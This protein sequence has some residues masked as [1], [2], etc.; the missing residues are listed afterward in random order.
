MGLSSMYDETEYKQYTGDWQRVFAW[1]PVRTISGER[2]WLQR[3]YRGTYNSISGQG[4]EYAT[5]VDLIKLHERKKNSEQFW[6]S[7]RGF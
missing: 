2:V 4:Y 6:G 3:V 1:L 5:L 7:R